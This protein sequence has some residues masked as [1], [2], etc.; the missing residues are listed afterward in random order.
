MIGESCALGV[1]VNRTNESAT[2]RKRLTVCTGSERNAL[3]AGTALPAIARAAS[4]AQSTL[5]RNINSAKSNDDRCSPR[6]ARGI[7]P[8]SKPSGVKSTRAAPS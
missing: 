2:S 6:G 8:R 7:G 4:I 5:S 1:L 3:A